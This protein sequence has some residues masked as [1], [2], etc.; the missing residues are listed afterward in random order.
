MVN[1]ATSLAWLESSDPD[2]DRRQPTQLSGHGS[3]YPSP[4]CNATA[5]LPRGLLTYKSG[6]LWECVQFFEDCEDLFHCHFSPLYLTMRKY[7]GLRGSGLNRAIIALVVWPAFACYSY[8]LAV[9]GG[10]LTL[11]SFIDTFPALDTITTSGEKQH[12]NSQIQGSWACLSATGALLT[13][14][15]NGG[16]AIYRRG[17]LWL[18]IMHLFW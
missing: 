6:S 13:I 17:H 8:N 4:H 1:A 15:R 11:P 2:P 3:S 16:C 7:L 18:F 9:I 12:F 14:S 5:L 10:V